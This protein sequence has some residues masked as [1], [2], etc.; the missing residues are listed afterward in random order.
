[1]S[2]VTLIA[3]LT[4]NEQSMNFNYYNYYVSKHIVVKGSKITLKYQGK[5]YFIFSR[6]RHQMYTYI[7]VLESV[8]S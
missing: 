8:K 2:T 5:N 1:M 4:A 6:L 3:G 7:S